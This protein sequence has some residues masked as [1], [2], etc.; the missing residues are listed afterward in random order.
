MNQWLNG[1]NRPALVYIRDSKTWFTVN[2]ETEMLSWTD[3]PKE[4]AWLSEWVSKSTET[5]KRAPAVSNSKRNAAAVNRSSEPISR[6]S[7]RTIRS[8]GI[9]LPMRRWDRRL[10]NRHS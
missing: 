10:G 6:R 3:D 5:E 8:H 1:G 7:S 2:S 9:V 4:I